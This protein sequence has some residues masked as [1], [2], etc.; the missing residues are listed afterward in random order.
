MTPQQAMF[1]NLTNAFL[2]SVNGDQSPVFT[3]RSIRREAEY[4]MD[5]EEFNRGCMRADEDNGDY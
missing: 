3:R 2:R 4:D 1:D 5:S